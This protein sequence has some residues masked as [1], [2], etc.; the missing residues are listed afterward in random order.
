MPPLKVKLWGNNVIISRY[1]KKFKFLNC[2]IENPDFLEMVA[3][4]WNNKIT[5]KPIYMVWRKFKRVQQIL[6]DL[7]KVTEGVQNIQ[8]S[9]T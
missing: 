5:R 6:T 9:R 7:N 1:Y 2:V 8:E 3:N 4:S